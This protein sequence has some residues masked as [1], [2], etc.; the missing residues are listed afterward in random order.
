MSVFQAQIELAAT[1]RARQRASAMR[2]FVWTA[3]RGIPRMRWMPN[4][5][6]SACTR[7][8][9]GPNPAPSADDGKRL[10][11]G[12]NRE[13][14]SISS[15]VKLLYADEV[16]VRSYHWMSTTT[17]CQPNDAMCSARY[18]ALAITS[19]SVTLAPYTFQLFQPIGG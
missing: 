18:S 14:S 16:A 1:S 8:A 4:R 13:N 11:A 17:Y 9:S 7:S 3:W 10:T 15:S 2:V 6:P 12:T 5:S 19:A